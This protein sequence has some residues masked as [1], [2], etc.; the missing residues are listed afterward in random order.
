MIGDW[1]KEKGR[2]PV[3]GLSTTK[4]VQDSILSDPKR[5]AVVDLIDIRYW[6]YQADGSAYAP[7]GGLSLAPRQHARLL[8][9][10]KTSFE[11][12]YRAVAEYRLR[13]PGKAVTYSAD[14]YDQFGW[15]VLLGGGSMAVL[16]P[17]P[18]GFLDGVSSMKPQSLVAEQWLLAGAG[19][20]LLYANDASQVNLS[21]LNGAFDYIVVHPGSGKQ[22]ASG[23]YISGRPW[24]Y[25]GKSA[26]VIRFLP[27][28]KK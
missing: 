20:A 7:Q 1:E 19:G 13:F 12:V 22:I 6:Y 3:I 5:A 9:P 10:R 24:T 18:E 16:P 4:D 14:N 11:Q 23:Q 15:A 17:L 21:Q 27:L 8:K 2:R 25:E 26:A 28:S